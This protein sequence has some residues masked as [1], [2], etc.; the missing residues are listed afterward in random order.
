MGSESF[1]RRIFFTFIV[2]INFALI[3]AVFGYF[4]KNVILFFLISIFLLLVLY[5]IFKSFIKEEINISKFEIFVILLIIFITLFNG[6]FYHDI[7]RGRDEMGYLA[8]AVKLTESGSLA[9]SDPLSFPYHPFRNLD[10]DVFTSRFLPGYIVYL[11]T[12][13]LLGGISLL[14]WANIF[15]FF[16]SLL[17][18]YFL[19]R[20]LAGRKVG[21][22]TILLFATFYTSLWFPRR[23][24][25][26]NLLMFLVFFGAW[27]LVASFK[28]KK[29]DYLILSLP[30]FSLAIFV[31]GEAFAYLITSLLIIFIGFIKFKEQIQ[32]N[33]K[34]LIPNIL[35][36]LFN[37]YLF[38]TYLVFYGKD[39][40]EYILDNASG[41]IAFIWQL[42]QYVL[43]LIILIVIIS[44]VFYY[45]YKNKFIIIHHS[46]IEKAR[47]ILLIFIFLTATL[48]EIYI[49][50]L[51][52]LKESLSWKIF[53]K[54]YVFQSFISYH[55]VFYLLI[56]FYGF[57]K[58]LFSRISYLV[59][60]VLSPT[61]IYLLSPNIAVDH[62]W[63]MRRFFPIFIPLIIIFVAITLVKIF[64]EKRRIFVVFLIL[65]VLNC[66]ITLPIFAFKENKGITGQIEKFVSKFSNNDLIL[67][68]PGWQW[69][70]WGYALHYLYHLNVLPNVDGYN[71]DN[72][73]SLLKKYKKIYIISSRKYNIYPGV[74]DSNLKYLYDW[75]LKYR[76]LQ[77]ETDF[78][79]YV[80]H[81]I[82]Q[83][84]VEKLKEN[85][86]NILPQKI[87]NAYE[88]YYVFEVTDKSKINLDQLFE[89]NENSSY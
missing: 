60:F 43:F 42:N 27:L 48:G 45:L 75:N 71:K 18:L 11:G 44:F 70:Q 34:I 37:L 51:L 38:K 54:Y 35:L 28:N 22:T 32:N 86:K 49:F 78:S 63:F 10:G 8:A 66:S 69:Q 13:Y 21:L 67:M 17:T 88:I 9:F 83:L 85:L 50:Y 14:F 52:N 81:N 40:I 29:I 23:T 24:V 64:K 59:I 56:T 58:K 33:I 4:K 3:L 7:P 30:V 61:F 79:Y 72:F 65:V 31:R 82:D 19:G 39:Y 62:P 74:E 89:Y 6:F 73:A 41:A 15:L 53:S 5:F 1:F 12:S 36:S 57:Y 2:F 47:K 76:Y 80:D 55:L 87:E 16:L 68:E 84:K 77:R 26:E 25:S 46:Q 20:S